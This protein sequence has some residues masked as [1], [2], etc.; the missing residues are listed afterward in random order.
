MDS[1]N[2][3]ES[4]INFIIESK[5]TSITDKDLIEYTLYK[6]EN[7]KKINLVKNQNSVCNV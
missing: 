7:I 1:Y 5:E 4:L 2:Q 6:L 3:I